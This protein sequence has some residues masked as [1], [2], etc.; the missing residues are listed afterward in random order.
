MPDQLSWCALGMVRIGNHT[1]IGISCQANR[2][3]D[4][5]NRRRQAIE[6]SEII[7][8]VPDLWL[9]PSRQAWSVPLL[10][11]PNRSIGPGMKVESPI[12]GQSNRFDQVAMLRLIQHD[13]LIVMLD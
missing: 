9:E 11:N 2:I 12:I 6:R 4:G 3:E 7:R 1:I 8:S 10:C 13:E 5:D